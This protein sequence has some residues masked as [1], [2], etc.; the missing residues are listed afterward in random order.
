MDRRVDLV[1][2]VAVSLFGIVLLLVAQGFRQDIGG[3][4]LGPRAFPQVVGIG[5][6]LTGGSV[7]LVN[8]RAI[9]SGQLM[10]VGGTKDDEGHPASAP[11]AF[12]LMGLTIGYAIVMTPLGFLFATP[13][14]FLTAL[15]TMQT[16]KLSSYIVLCVGY[17]LVIY[18]VFALLLNIPLPNGILRP[19]LHTL[20]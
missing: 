15:R 10:G 16:T 17:T 14:Y 20:Q 7:F 2:G 19:L 5:L 6:F 4:L 3:D 8:L 9:R 18:A 13:L 12:M 1:L 11:R